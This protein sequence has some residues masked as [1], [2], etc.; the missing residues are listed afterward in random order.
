[1]QR[2]EHPAGRARQ[3]DEAQQLPLRGAQHARVGQHH[4]TD[5]L[6]ALVDVEE[7]DKEHQRDGQRHLG[8]DAQPEPHAED[9]RQDHAWHRVGGL[10]VRVQHGRGG[11][12]QRQPQ[13]RAQAGGGADA[14]GEHG[15]GQR[16]AEMLVDVALRDE[17]RPDALGNDQRLPEEER[18]ILRAR[19]NVPHNQGGDQQPE[20]PGTQR[21]RRNRTIG[22]GRERSGSD[23]AARRCCA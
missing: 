22:H 4:R 14:E 13:P 17:P 2:R 19:G 8:P 9:R 1:M 18:H 7:D 3:V 23:Q 21:K 16:D 20:L 11:R 12:A 5:L 6:H 10:D 15:L